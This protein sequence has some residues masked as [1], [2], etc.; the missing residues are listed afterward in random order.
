MDHKKI[1][2]V[3]IDSSIAVQLNVQAD[4]P[5]QARRLVENAFGLANGFDSAIKMLHV[6]YCRSG[7]E[8]MCPGA[9]VEEMECEMRNEYEITGP[10]GSSANGSNCSSLE[11]QK[12]S[13]FDV[14]PYLDRKEEPE[15]EEEEIDFF[16]MYLLDKEPER[17]PFDQAE[18]YAD[19]FGE[20][21]CAEE[22]GETGCELFYNGNAVLTVDGERYLVGPAMVYAVE[23]DLARP[24]TDA[25]IMETVKVLKARTTRVCVEDD[26]FYALKL[27]EEVEDEEEVDGEE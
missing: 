11:I 26:V 5:E 7:I 18:D 3:A 22:F 9:V 19:T 13:I 14:T 23:D 15:E 1:F 17:I 25:Q 16:L 12:D 2:K 10:D 8:Q 4:N 20:R 24:L 21:P 27:F 6:Q